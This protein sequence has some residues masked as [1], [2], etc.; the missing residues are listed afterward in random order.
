MNLFVEKN[1]VKFPYYDLRE[2]AKQNGIECSDTTTAEELSAQMQ[3]RWLRA[4]EHQFQIPK[5]PPNARDLFLL[6]KLGMVQEIEPPPMYYEG[7][8]LLG[9]SIKDTRRRLAFILHSWGNI[10]LDTGTIYFLV[11]ERDVQNENM[12]GLYT[13]DG[14][15]FKAEWKPMGAMLKT[16]TDVARTIWEQSVIPQGMLAKFVDTPLQP[17]ETAEITRNPNTTDTM[18]E[19]MKCNPTQGIW[20]LASSQPFIQRQL[21]NVEATLKLFPGAYTIVEIGPETSPDLPLKAYLDEVARL[22]YQQLLA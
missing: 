17:T 5:G 22:L 3:A 13:P 19:F 4:E 14:I 8:L 9:A 16:E 10:N 2:L 11:S 7:T 18:V 15:P 6:N 20:L 1:G 12:D 21:L